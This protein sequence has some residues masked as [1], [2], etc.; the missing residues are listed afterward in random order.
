MGPFEEVSI[1][2]MLAEPHGGKTDNWKS[3]SELRGSYES[4]QTAGF[5]EDT[6]LWS[7]LHYQPPKELAFGTGEEKPE[8]VILLID[9]R[10]G[11]GQ[12]FLRTSA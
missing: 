5:K 7:V 6:A 10:E 1:T 2:H 11:G 3:S 4:R 9:L 8:F 12:Q